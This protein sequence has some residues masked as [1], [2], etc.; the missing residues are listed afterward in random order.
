MGRCGDD[1]TLQLLSHPNNHNGS[2][3]TGSCCMTI[4]ESWFNPLSVVLTHSSGGCHMAPMLLEAADNT[5][6]A[7]AESLRLR[8]RPCHVGSVPMRAIKVL[9][10]RRSRSFGGASQFG[11]SEMST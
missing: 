7:S 8:S 3:W 1:G 6:I 2:S 11:H 4:A 5:G 9:R 10:G